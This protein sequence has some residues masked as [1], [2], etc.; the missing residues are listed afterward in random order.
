MFYFK[1]KEKQQKLENEQ[2]LGSPLVTYF[3][4]MS[5]VAELYKTIRTNI[6]FAQIGS[7]INS[8]AVTSSISMEGKST[9]T[10]NLAYTYAQ[11]GKKY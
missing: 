3:E 7:S 4:P 5:A 11:T 9:T 2:K 1:S 8:I 10:V 6:E